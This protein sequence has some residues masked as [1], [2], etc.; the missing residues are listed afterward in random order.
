MGSPRSG[1]K[2]LA[3]CVAA[4]AL[5]AAAPARVEAGAWA[6]PAGQGQVIVSLTDSG[7]DHDFLADGRGVAAPPYRKLEGTALV[8]YG[9]TGW[10]T[11]IA[12]PDLLSVRTT[13]PT[14]RYDG[15]GQSGAGIRARIWQ[16]GS[17]ALSIQAMGYL[18]GPR[19]HGDTAQLG[20]ADAETDWRLLAGH[21]FM[22]GKW[23]GFTDVELAY[24]TRAGAPADEVHLDLTLGLRPTPRVL[25]ML[26]S[27]TTV[28][29]GPAQAPFLPG[30]WTK[31]EASVVYD[32]TP[33]WSVQLG[34]L[35]TVLGVNA[36]HERGF[37][38][39]VW[40]RF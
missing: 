26:Q 20:Y 24:R 40:H 30:R 28:T 8:E 4:A 18:P 13:W 27:F 38:A 14:S 9:L 33:R 35:T 39:G 7:G 22:L 2:T 3:P 1:A 10:L 32:L 12:A 17:T 23:S 31:L 36:L 19:R 6:Q 25:V 11:A 37:V 29:Y 16:A 21:S 5:L 34:A 15:F